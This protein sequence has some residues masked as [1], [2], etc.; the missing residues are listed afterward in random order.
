M[1]A[2]H[3]RD[4]GRGQSPL[5]RDLDLLDRGKLTGDEFLLRRL[6]RGELKTP[7]EIGSLPTRVW[8]EWQR[9]QRE[10][11][12]GWGEAGF[13]AAKPSSSTAGVTPEEMKL[14]LVGTNLGPPLP[15]VAPESE[16]GRAI[17]ARH[18]AARDPHWKRQMLLW[19]AEEKAIHYIAGVELFRFMAPG[20]TCVLA[21]DGAMTPRAYEDVS[22]SRPELLQALRRGLTEKEARALAGDGLSAEERRLRDSALYGLAYAARGIGSEDP[23]K[24]LPLIHGL[25]DDLLVDFQR[26]LSRVSRER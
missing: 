15:N 8:A 18:V 24:R 17:E 7:D 19:Q 9:R 11:P 3:D 1:G 25:G 13:A 12:S 21:L 22:A 2:G 10:G 5:E 20:H 6:E 26:E 14:L 4:R 16:L 23:P